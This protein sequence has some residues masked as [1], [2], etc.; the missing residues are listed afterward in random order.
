MTS[1]SETKMR[2]VATRQLKVVLRGLLVLLATPLFATG[3][4]GQ[5]SGVLIGVVE[6]RSEA[7]QDFASIHAP[8]YQTLWVA[9]DANGKLIVLAT[10]P[11]L[12]VPRRDGF[13]HVGVKQVCEFD[14][15]T[16]DGG[17]NESVGQTIWTAPVAKAGEVEQDHPCTP[18]KPEDYASPFGRSDEDKNKISQC[19]FTLTNIEFLSPELISLRKYS[20]QSED[21]EPRGGRY[22][23]TDYVRRIDSAEA[24]SFGGLLGPLAT[25]AYTKALPEKAQDGAGEDCGEPSADSDTGWGIRRTSRR[26]AAYASLSLG[27]FGCSASGVID[28]RIPRSLTGESATPFDWKTFVA[29]EKELQ[30]GYVS[31][32][33]DLAIAVTKTEMKFYEVREKVPGKVLLSLPARAIVMVQWATGAHVPDW[34]AQLQ[35]IAGQPLLGPVVRVKS[36]AK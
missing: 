3:A 19:G 10:I 35:K 8:K 34:T 23:E 9:P 5:Q 22:S 27:N 30:D 1:V 6:G 21:C 36:A 28:F 12:I 17:G 13:W 4:R 20:G 16:G 32:T 29:I 25:K 2:M 11:E 15:G 33:G 26:W 14:E 31:P 7:E 18:H 24:V